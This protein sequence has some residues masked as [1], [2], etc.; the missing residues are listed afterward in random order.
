[1]SSDPRQTD[2]HGF[3]VPPTFE[4][5]GLARPDQAGPERPRFNLRAW[6][7]VFV[8]LGVGIAAAVIWTTPLGQQLRLQ[9]ANWIAQRGYDKY[10]NGD[11]QGALTDLDTAIA[12]ADGAAS[13][14]DLRGV[15]RLEAGQL[16]ESLRDFNKLLDI[17]P[18][19]AHGYMRRSLV[20]QRLNRHDEAI[21]DLTRAIELSS[22]AESS[23]WN[24]RAYARA[25]ANVEL[26]A[27]LADVEKALTLLKN[28][29]P[30]MTSDEYNESLAAFL[31]TRGYLYYLLD[32]YEEGLAD[33]DE[34]L[35]LAE[36]AVPAADA[37]DR[38]TLQYR[39]RKW[40]EN[41]SVMYHHR[42]L[43]HEK[44]GNAEQAARDLKRGDELGYNPQAGV[45]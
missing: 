3:P 35:R 40:E 2:R 8:V 30:T 31:D 36:E 14:H 6:R 43:I 21:A 34:A 17:S 33:M 38:R 5:L 25:I 28:K 12:W 37:A 10:L 41:L 18:D 7:W 26:D 4:E 32:R 19:Y 42:G 11:L 13:F 16:E 23:P 20:Y 27:A 15:I 1:M 22:D 39:T 29:R 44:L 45:F 9:A 24:A